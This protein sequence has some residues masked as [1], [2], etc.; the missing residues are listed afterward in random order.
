MQY[1]TIVLQLIRNHPQLHYQLRQARQ[2]LDATE[3]CS[4]SLK[5]RHE[6]LTTTLGQKSPSRNP[7]QLSQEALEIALEEFEM[8]L[9][10]ELSLDA[11]MAF[12]LGHSQT[13]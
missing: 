13:A 4:M 7:Q 10:P 11:A 2:L 12:V 9:L 6:E 1:K 8:H 3:A 5:Q